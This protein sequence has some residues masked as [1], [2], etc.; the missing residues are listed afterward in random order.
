M[1]LL[2]YIALSSVLALSLTSC[3]DWLDINVNPNQPSNE[4]IQVENRLPWIQKQYTYSAGCA[5]TRTFATCGGFYS[6]NGNMNKAS[7]T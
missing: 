2:K 1:K 4:S 7:V 3:D 5:N 6:N